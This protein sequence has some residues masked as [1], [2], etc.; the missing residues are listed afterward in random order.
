MIS[1]EKI[2]RRT[3]GVEIRDVVIERCI[4][5][6]SWYRQPTIGGLF[7]CQ[8]CGFSFRIS[9][10]E[11]SPDGILRIDLQKGIKT[12]RMALLDQAASELDGLKGAIILDVG[13]DYEDCGQGWVR[14]I[15]KGVEGTRR[16]EI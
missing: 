8:R 10:A 9:H 12:S 14:Y 1:T 6:E 15:Y 2:S 16:F 13:L 3:S 11:V 7:H 5:G 4:C